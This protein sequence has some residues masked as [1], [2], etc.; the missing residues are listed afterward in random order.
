MSVFF[1]KMIHKKNGRPYS[2]KPVYFTNENLHSLVLTMAAWWRILV[3]TEI[4]SYFLGMILVQHI[5]NG[6]LCSEKNYPFF[7][8]F[9]ISFCL[10]LYK[11]SYWV[12]SVVSYLHNWMVTPTPLGSRVLPTVFFFLNICRVKPYRNSF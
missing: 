5:S 1:P 10:F 6:L 12:I 3:E 2:S 4:I 7:E 8:F 9:I 11:Y